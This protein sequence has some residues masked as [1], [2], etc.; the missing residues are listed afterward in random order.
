MSKLFKF[1][2]GGTETNFRLWSGLPWENKN[3]KNEPK[4]VSV[5][6]KHLKYLIPI[7]FPDALV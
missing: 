2:C 4:T 3:G 1:P 6:F 5:D 7:V